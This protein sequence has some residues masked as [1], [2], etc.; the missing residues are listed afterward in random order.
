MIQIIYYP[1]REFQLYDSEIVTNNKLKENLNF[2]YTLSPEFLFCPHSSLHHQ[3]STRDQLS[4][5]CTIYEESPAPQHQSL[6]W[7]IKGQRQEKGHYERLL[8][9]RK[10]ICIF[11]LATEMFAYKKQTGR[12]EE[13]KNNMKEHMDI[14]ERKNFAFPQEMKESPTA[15]ALATSGIPLLPTTTWHRDENHWNGFTCFVV[16]YIQR[17]TLSFIH[18]KCLN[19]FY[20]LKNKFV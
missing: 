17:K 10:F 1:S 12:V 11:Q 14:G 9:V 5:W 19:V 2:K 18:F 13:K 6:L 3:S 15:N 16:K 8:K 20:N 7:I 4:I